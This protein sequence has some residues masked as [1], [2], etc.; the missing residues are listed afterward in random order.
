MRK[1]SLKMAAYGALVS[2]KFIIDQ[3]RSHPHPPISL[4]QK[5]VESLIELVTF[6]QDF[7]EGY[8]SHVGCT[9]EEDY[10]E[11][12]IAEAAYHAEDVIESYIV[13][14]I[15][16]RS[17]NYEENISS[18]QFHQGLA[19]FTTKNKTV[20]WFST[21]MDI[22]PKIS[23]Q[24]VVIILFLTGV[25]KVLENMNL[26][27]TKIKEKMVV[28]DQ[29]HIMK[30]LSTAR[31]T[32][33]AQN[34][35]MIGFDEIFYQMLDKITGGG[36]GREIIPIVGMGGIG[37]T[38]LA[39]NIYVSPLVQES[40]DVCVWLTISQEYNAWQILGQ[41]LDQVG[42]GGMGD[43]REDELG[44]HLYKYLIGKE[45]FYCNG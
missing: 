39:R 1:L 37:K 41:V 26:I 38:T 42:Q 17:R 13:D 25:E 15:L 6:L 3:I 40:F 44:E 23:N 24:V 19:Y 14:Q 2:V 29:L 4:H 32:T 34:V 9:E 45:V 12:R 31:S 36:L 35:I 21:F 11:S 5:Q 18:D 16:V 43:L 28:Q 7:L 33:T 20:C 22:S 27:K 10:W 8:S 30:P